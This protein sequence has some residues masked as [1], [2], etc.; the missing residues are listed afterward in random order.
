MI[1]CI[2]RS[3]STGVPA[4]FRDDLLSRGGEARYYSARIS[5]DNCD[6]T[7]DIDYDDGEK[8]NA[9]KE[10]RIRSS[11]ASLGTKTPVSSGDPRVDAFQGELFN[12]YASQYGEQAARAYFGDIHPS[13]GSS[14]SRPFKEGEKVEV[15]KSATRGMNQ[16][17][18]VT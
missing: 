2:L 14:S 1:V 18:R 12:H 15:R 16:K 17:P 7:Y 11:E 3:Q 5:R 10:D 4:S 6:K 9:V 8:E 13:G